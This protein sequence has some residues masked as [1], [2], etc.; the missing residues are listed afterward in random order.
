MPSAGDLRRMAAR[1]A[2]TCTEV[3]LARGRTGGGRACR[4]LAQRRAGRCG[5]CRTLAQRRSG[6]CGARP[7]C[8]SPCRASPAPTRRPPHSAAACPAGACSTGQRY[9]WDAVR[10]HARGCGW[11]RARGGAAVR[12][13]ALVATWRGRAFATARASGAD[14]LLPSLAGLQWLADAPALELRCG[15][16]HWYMRGRPALR[17]TDAVRDMPGVAVGSGRAAARQAVP[18]PLFRLGA[19]GRSA[20]RAAVPRVCCCLPWRDF[21]GLRILRPGPPWP[22]VRDRARQWRASAVAHP[23]GWWVRCS[24][25]RC[26]RATRV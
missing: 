17:M 22:G 16:P 3:I 23:L 4:T 1:V 8:T 10:N 7:A 11:F 18:A 13:G 9:G 12:T 26:S 19:A 5:A 14:S 6:R 25:C 2:W 15:L 24:F 20:G 21:N